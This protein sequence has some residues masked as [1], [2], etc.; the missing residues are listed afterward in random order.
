MDASI[1]GALRGIVH[2]PQHRP[3]TGVEISVRSLNSDWKQSAITDQQGEFVFSS[4]PLGRY[5]VTATMSGFA[6]DRQEI[7]VVSGAAPVLHIALSIEKVNQEIGVTSQAAE[8]DPQSSASRTTIGREEIARTPGAQA[9]NSLS[10]ITDYV[11]GSNMV[12][13]QL[14]IRGGHQ[15]TWLIDGVPVPNTNIAGNVGPQFDPKN[16]QDIEVQRGGYSAQSGDRTYGVFNVVTRSGFER[17]RE[18]EL[19]AGYGNFHD[20]DDQI[21]FGDHTQKFAYYASVGA[22]RS[23]L[24]L[25]TPEAGVHHAQNAAVNGF[26]SL[27]FNPRTADQ[28]RF[29]AAARND[30]FQ[31]PNTLTDQIAGRRDAEN[32]RDL[33]TNLTWLHTMGKGWVLT[34]SPFYHFNRSAYEGGAN[35]VP[36]V[37][38]ERH[39]SSYYG[40]VFDAA[41]LS[42][43]HNARVG[44]QGF[45]QND[46]LLFGLTAN[47]GSGLRL[48]QSDRQTGSLNA[49][50]AEDQYRLTQ[51]FTINGGVR[52]T[53]FSGGLQETSVDPRIGG[54]LTLP[55]VHAVLRAFYGRY[56]QAPPLA[57]VSGPLEQFAISQGVGFLP[58]HGETDE[59]NELGIALPIRGWTFDFSRFVTHAKN[60]FDH[61]V[62]GDSN[63]FL[64]L[65]IERARIHGVE[66]LVR[67]PKLKNRL[68]AHLA[69]SRQYVEGRGG[70]SGGLTDF[71]PGT[72]GY[73]YLDHDQR[74][75]LSA[76]FSADLPARTWLSANLNYGSGFLD[77]NGPQH[78]PNHTSLDISLGKD[79][80]GHWVA[81]LSA[82]NIGDRR[83]LLDN[84]NTFGGTHFA[85]PRRVSVQVKYRFHY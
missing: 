25:E 7:V 72:A 53:H 47:D 57:T 74:D 84:S 10:M 85:D 76:G 33:F 67:S 82:T 18:G 5:A 51:W 36:L 68:V 65:T 31:I 1:F 44:F 48:H 43:Q 64:P 37:T 32:E 30:H 29:V 2:D 83:Y 78:L 55:K 3:V 63:I 23:D 70:V 19:L 8:V 77:G 52:L 34:F 27:I 81:Q 21:S 66:A 22:N 50:Y 46:G 79:V 75:T 45:G 17:D 6:T 28:I 15:V 11:P 56:Y 73:F 14:H 13:D 42:T 4:V 58:L 26:T 62:L 12:H 39:S 24:G 80:G 40:G 54:A 49:V 9:A 38:D 20:T 16:I 35:D 69:F 41:W 71:T 59:Q 61:D 60:F